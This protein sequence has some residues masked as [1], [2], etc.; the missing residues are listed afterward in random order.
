VRDFSR[1]ENFA[2]DLQCV[3]NAVLS[4]PMGLVDGLRNALELGRASGAP[5]TT[6]A[7]TPPVSAP[8][9][10]PWLD[11]RSAAGI[12]A[13]WRCVSLIADTISD[14]PWTE[15][16]GPA[17]LEPSRLVR[18]P[19]VTMDRGEWTWRV[20]ATEA[21]YN[22]SY[23]LHVGGTD[24]EG[25]PW[26]LLPIPPGVCYP[27][28]EDPWNLMPAT[29]Y[30]VAGQVVPAELLTIVRR[31]PWP[32]IS[33][34]LA[35]ILDMA[36]R[37]F[38]AYLAA[39]VANAR[40]WTSGGPVTTVITTD[41]ELDQTDADKIAQRWID[42]RSLGADYPAVLGKGAH[43]EPWG[44][45]PTKEAS[46]EARREMTADVGRY[47]G[48]PTRILNAPA[49]DS[50]TY[51]NNEHDATDLLRYCLRG[52][53]RPLEGAIST[54]LPGDAQVGRRMALDPSQLVSGDL[55][56]RA[57]AYPAL[58]NAGILTAEE[59]RVRGFGL[60]AAPA[61]G[62]LRTSSPA[63]IPAQEAPTTPA[64]VTVS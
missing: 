33:E 26:S 4:R 57:I 14:M 30:A 44:A 24:G 54:L 48:V 15:W 51:S 22:T 20:I 62:E 50:E 45:D 28:D 17:Q 2:T 43:A 27:L 52:Y 12:S 38:T 9:P 5:A 29:R 42:R 3:R 63:A 10:I 25:M 47:F 40:Y 21:L 61:V 1:G 60:P 49:G 36:R 39:D 11:G 16:R 19:M 8:T 64:T 55:Q 53:M 7:T 58:V 31:A 6:T 59:A 13:V 18:R 56:S 41:Q 23:L 46:V 35:G 32:G 37:Q 34:Q